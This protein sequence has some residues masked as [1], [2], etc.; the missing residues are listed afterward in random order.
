MFNSK[1][2]HKKK[3][4][5]EEAALINLR[6]KKAPAYKLYKTPVKT[7][8]R[9]CCLYSYLVHEKAKQVVTDLLI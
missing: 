7:T 9:V 5:C 2:T 1:L 4:F 8:V 6:N 3:F